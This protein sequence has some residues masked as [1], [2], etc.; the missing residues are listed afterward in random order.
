[1]TSGSSFGSM[2]T[3]PHRLYHPAAT[4]PSPLD[5]K[6]AHYKSNYCMR[7]AARANCFLFPFS[8]I[9]LFG[10]CRS[11]AYQQPFIGASAH[12]TP[13]DKVHLKH[14]GESGRSR[15]QFVDSAPPRYPMRALVE[16]SSSDHSS[17]SLGLH[18][19]TNATCWPP[20]NA[21]CWPPKLT[22]L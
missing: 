11:P 7:S 18:D 20:K 21:T 19:R 10:S 14:T 6:E 12:S 13:H 8:G 4:L 3:T 1:M 15:F 2:V 9:F 5:R 16:A 22:N 17:P